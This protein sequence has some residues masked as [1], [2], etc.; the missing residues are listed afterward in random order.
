LGDDLERITTSLPAHEL[1]RTYHAQ[2]AIHAHHL[3]HWGAYVDRHP[4][5]RLDGAI[6]HSVGVVAALVAAEALSVEDSCV[7]VHERARAFGEICDRLPEPQTLVAVFGDDVEE[8]FEEFERFG[9][10]IALHNSVGK[11]VLG[12]RSADLERLVDESKRE[13]WPVRFKRLPVQGPYHTRAFE[14]CRDRLRLC[15]NSIELRRPR[16]PV[17]MG[18]SGAAET[19]P[20]RIKQL[21]AEQ[22]CSRERHLDAVRAAYA[23]GCRSF[24]EIAKSPQPIRWLPEQLPQ[25]DVEWRAVTTAEL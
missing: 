5:T 6:G 15:L 12:G 20:A 23:A 25:P 2:R 22:V 3:G 9:A 18:T 4:R 11:I 24:I 10:T 19:D 14:P 1:S 16:C 7:F 8:N 17:F 21:L 13:G